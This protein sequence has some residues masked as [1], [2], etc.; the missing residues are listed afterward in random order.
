M[1]TFWFAYLLAYSLGPDQFYPVD[2]TPI[3]PG[4]EV[5]VLEILG[6]HG[7][8]KAQ[9]ETFAN[10]QRIR[11]AVTYKLADYRVLRSTCMAITLPK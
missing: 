9:C 2:K 8:T 11:A 6:P 7:T 4:I 3:A 10:G 5:R 1:V